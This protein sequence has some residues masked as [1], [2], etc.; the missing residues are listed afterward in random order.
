[1]ER[2]IKHVRATPSEGSIKTKVS[3]VREE[4]ARLEK[5][6]VDIRARKDYLGQ[7]GLNE[8]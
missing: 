4:L 5:E 7:S 2:T 1:M 8:I 3:K 6:R